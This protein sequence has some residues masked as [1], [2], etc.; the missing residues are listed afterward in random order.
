MQH[1]M[2]MMWGCVAVI[3]L[4]AVL[5]VTGSGAGH[6][7]FVLPCALM[8]GAMVWVTMRGMGGGSRGG[9]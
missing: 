7:L 9:R 2:K 4:V 6:L 1:S 5:A 8:M 3:V